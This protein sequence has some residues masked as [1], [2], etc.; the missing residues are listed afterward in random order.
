MAIITNLNSRQTPMVAAGSTGTQVIKF[1]DCPRVYIKTA[2]VSPTPI[3]T[4]SNGTLPAGYTDL[5]IV[6]GKLKIQYDKEQKEVRTGLDEILRAVYVGKKTAG[7]E[8]NLTQFDDVAVQQLTGLAPSLINGGS[9]AQFAVGSEDVV[10]KALLLVVQNKIDGREW[11]FYHP[12][13]YMTFSLSDSGDATVM[14]GKA[15]CTA[16]L[17]GGTDTYMIQTMFA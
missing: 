2:D 10:Q 14:V 17:Y 9:A 5:G 12:A 7:F 6:D 13:A 11:Q 15:M 3:T 1:I 4:K 16:F 8:F